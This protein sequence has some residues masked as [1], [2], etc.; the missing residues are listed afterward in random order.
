VPDPRVP[1]TDMNGTTADAVTANWRQDKYTS[2]ADPV[3]VAT[4][5]EAQLIV[6]EARGGQEAVA[7]INALRDQYGL[8]PFAST[9]EAEIQAQIQEERR[10]ELFLEGHRLGDM[11][12]HNLPLFP[13]TGAP[14]N[15]GGTYGDARC[16]PL[17]DVER[18]NNPNL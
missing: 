9:D 2:N 17:P 3:P 18:R 8:D 13:A 11:R 5:E 16:F 4:W 15:K 10:R 14:Y 12:R 1:V 7:I 6:A